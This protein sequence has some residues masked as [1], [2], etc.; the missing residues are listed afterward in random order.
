MSVRGVFVTDFD[1][2]VT[3]RDFYRLVIDTLAPP[4]SDRYWSQYLSGEITHFDALRLTYASA[5]QGEPA[6]RA[7]IDRMEPDPDLA[8]E[9]RTLQESGWRVV[10]AS[11]GCSWYIDP[12][13][14]AA[15]VD[16][17]C[18]ANPGRIEGG[19]LVMERPVDSPYPSIETG[20]DKA[21]VVRAATRTDGEIAFAGDGRTDLE[22]ALLVV[23][24]LRFARGDLAAALRERGESFRPFR[25]WSE[26]AR[27]IRADSESSGPNSGRGPQILGG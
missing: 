10:V 3:R 12:I 18:H 27:A 13:L 16:L 9:V 23:P 11:A 26:A 17:E 19:R 7:L 20:I 6:L 4:G 14:E 8:E 22:A 25:R 5:E 1:G 2:T 24:G 21:A 15:G